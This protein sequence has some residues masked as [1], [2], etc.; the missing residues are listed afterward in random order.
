MNGYHFRVNGPNCF[1]AT[2]IIIVCSIN[3]TKTEA[4]DVYSAISPNN[5]GPSKKPLYPSVDTLA[6]AAPGEIERSSAALLKQTGINI[7]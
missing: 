6:I 1:D 5:S 7:A 2:K 4:M 3:I